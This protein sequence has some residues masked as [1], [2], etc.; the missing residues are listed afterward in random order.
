MVVL[1]AMFVS[2]G[3]TQ[4]SQ[5]EQS[6]RTRGFA[7]A[8]LEMY[9]DSS[10]NQQVEY[11]SL[12]NDGDFVLRETSTESQ[13]DANRKLLGRLGGGNNRNTN[14]SLLL[15]AIGERGFELVETEVNGIGTLRIFVRRE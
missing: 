12:W 9:V 11:V 13:L 8:T 4:R 15:N 6:R 5:Q 14:L 3:L 1:I 2:I 10:A 7:Y